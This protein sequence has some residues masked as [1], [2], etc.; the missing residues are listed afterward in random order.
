MNRILERWKKANITTVLEAE[1]EKM[2]RIAAR[3]KAKSNTFSQEL[4][5][6][7][8]SGVFDNFDRK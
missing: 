7:E 6:F 1:R 8:R 5:E 4:E 2:E 3:T